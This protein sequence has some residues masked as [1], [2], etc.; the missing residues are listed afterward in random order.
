MFVVS[1]MKKTQKIP[2]TQEEEKDEFFLLLEEKWK[3]IEMTHLVKEEEEV[4]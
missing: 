1:I 2:P 4:K 3:K